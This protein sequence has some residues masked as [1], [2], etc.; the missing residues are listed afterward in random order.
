MRFIIGIFLLVASYIAT[1]QTDYDRMHNPP[2]SVDGFCANVLSDG[3]NT[4]FSSWKDSVN[5]KYKICNYPAFIDSTITEQLISKAFDIIEYNIGMP[6]IQVFDSAYIDIKYDYLD[7]VGG[8]LGISEFPPI[9]R[10][11]KTPISVLFDKY[12]IQPSFSDSDTIPSR[13]DPLTIY[14][15][16][17]GHAFGLQHTDIPHSIMYPKYSA[18]FSDYAVDDMLGLRSMYRNKQ[19]FRFGKHKYI[20][21]TKE[22]VKI[23]NYFNRSEFFTK[24]NLDGHYLDS[25]VIAGVTAI[26]TFYDCPIKITSSYRDKECNRNANGAVKSQH[27]LNN[28]IDWKFTGPKAAKAMAQYKKD[29]TNKKP[30]L[31]QL[32]RLGIT[33]FGIYKTSFHIDTRDSYG[34]NHYMNF[35]YTVWNSWTPGSF[36]DDDVENDIYEGL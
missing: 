21:V 23:N 26:R 36:F 29:I 5:V 24:C 33:G 6:I 4:S 25:A 28:A 30:I 22:K 11:N 2:I 27:L 34:A 15:H 7:G 14:L 8:T 31:G 9:S 35:R 12:D 32:L 16:E 17:L 13:Y 20:W 1:A 18:M 19:T 3:Y 10:I